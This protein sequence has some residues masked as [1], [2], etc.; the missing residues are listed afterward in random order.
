MSR[1]RKSE[2]YE[3]EICEEK[4]VSSLHKHHIIEQT[5]IDTNNEDFNLAIICAS[6]HAKVHAG[7][8][9]LLGIVPSTKM[10]NRRTL[11]Y[12]K[13]GECN[14]PGLEDYKPNFIK[15]RKSTKIN[16]K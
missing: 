1:K 3:C 15:K 6:C 8:I 7:S 5:D 13:D 16:L 4:E 11:I 14:I 10:P 9:D 2:K 12:I